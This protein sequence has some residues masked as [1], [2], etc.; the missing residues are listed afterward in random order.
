MIDAGSA[1][2][3]PTKV[4]LDEDE[5]SEYDNEDIMHKL[6]EAGIIKK[7]EVINF[8]ERGPVS[9]YLNNEKVPVPPPTHTQP[10]P[11]R[12]VRK[13]MTMDMLKAEDVI[14]QRKIAAFYEV[15]SIGY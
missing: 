2:R 15:N 4:W 9:T 1:R 5:E 11:T 8:T 12:V 3:D 13:R 14:I 6:R 10:S 7:N